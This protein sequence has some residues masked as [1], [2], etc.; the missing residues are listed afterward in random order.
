M[1]AAS[2]TPHREETMTLTAP[3]LTQDEQRRLDQLNER[4][5][6]S[7]R[8]YAQHGGSKKWFD[9]CEKDRKARDEFLDQCDPSRIEERAKQRAREEFLMDCDIV[10]DL[11]EVNDYIDFSAEFDGE[12]EDL[13]TEYHTGAIRSIKKRLRCDNDYAEAVLTQVFGPGR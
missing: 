10:R 3:G 11:G 5:R 1:H 2:T 7:Q 9:E 12:D 8:M 6:Q 4:L 13:A